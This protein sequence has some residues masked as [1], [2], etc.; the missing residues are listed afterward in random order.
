MTAEFLLYW[1]TN[2][3]SVAD[4]RLY[5]FGGT[6]FRTIHECCGSW[7][8]IETRYLEGVICF[9]DALSFTCSRVVT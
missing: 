8:I 9:F 5:Q 1:R 3:E 7:A 2:C 6:H 4:T